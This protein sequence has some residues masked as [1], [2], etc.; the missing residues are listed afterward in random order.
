[1][2]RFTALSFTDSRSR[3]Q[4]KLNSNLIFPPDRYSVSATDSQ[5]DPSPREWGCAALRTP[6][7]EGWVILHTTAPS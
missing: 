6:K 3:V 2:R 4:N 7:G 5:L 1:M